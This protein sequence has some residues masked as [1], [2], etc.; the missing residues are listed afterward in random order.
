MKRFVLLVSVL[1]GF[2]V[3]AFF[4]AGAAPTSAGADNREDSLWL[5]VQSAQD[6]TTKIQALLKLAAIATD[7]TKALERL[8]S[9]VAIAQDVGLPYWKAKAQIEFAEH[10]RKNRR[11]ALAMDYIE[12]AIEILEVQPPGKLLVRAYGVAGQLAWTERSAV[13]SIEYKTK[14][15]D[16][17]NTPESREQYGKALNNLG[18]TYKNASLEVKALEALLEALEIA[19][20][21][22]D[23]T[24]IGTT[25]NNI[26]NVYKNREEYDAALKT[27]W[28]TLSIRRKLNDPQAL[29][30]THNNLGLVHRKLNHSD[31]A[32]Y[33]FA[34]SI[35]IRE[36]TGEKRRLSY[37]YNNLGLLFLDER[38]LDSALKYLNYSLELKHA[39]PSDHRDLG[40]AYVNLAETYLAQGQ[41]EMASN[42]LEKTRLEIEG[43][44]YIEIEIARLE[45]LARVFAQ[46]NQYADA[47]NYI[48]IHNQLKDSL[49]R[50]NTSRNLRDVQSSFELEKSQNEIT[51]LEQE[52]R[53]KELELQ[54][55]ELARNTL[56]MALLAIIIIAVMLLLRSRSIQQL[57]KNLQEANAT[58][59]ATRVSK[60]EKETLLKEIHHRV[61]NNLQII[62]SLLRL[63]SEN[64]KDPEVLAQFN[65]SQNRI[66]SMALVHE[67]L[68]RSDDFTNINMQAYFTKLCND[69][70]QNYAVGKDIKV[71]IRTEVDRMGV[72]TLIPLGL[73]VN[74]MIT[75]ALKHA[76]E[77]SSGNMAIA[78]RSLGEKQ[79]ELIV[80]DDG[81]GF[82]PELQHHELHSLG[83]ELIHTLA[84]QLDG[85]VKMDNQ[86]GARYTIRFQCQD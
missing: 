86:P 7:T 55:A 14:W 19:E 36:P 42:Y 63:Q 70:I 76:F 60:E 32:R 3:G 72:N 24:Q 10:F 2:H 53:L 6:D 81:K 75:N 54:N 44:G 58:L 20:E 62:T 68:Y 1:F 64:I 51:R 74:E 84:E 8:G 22:K 29:A 56:L 77:G 78:L 46:K 23:S 45:V 16:G 50:I 49:N 39:A 71:E 37:A 61:K 31:S 73:M 33:H 15:A 41:S 17:L 30:D 12:E 38:I 21:F 65:E 80:S 11:Y 83:V 9:A 40:I 57:N 52:Q 47:Y 43:K 13:K 48:L 27:H 67:E 26:G 4:S 35:E 5:V 82:P 69:L 25:L 34:K 59:Q 85:S 28:R 66:R 79:Y 18:V